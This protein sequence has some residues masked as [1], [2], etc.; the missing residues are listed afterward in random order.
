[1][2]KTA[3]VYI[4]LDLVCKE[5]ETQY[6]MMKI[7]DMVEKWKEIRRK[8]RDREKMPINSWAGDL[9]AK[10]ANEFMVPNYAEMCEKQFLAE[11]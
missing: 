1:M 6:I 4:A 10:V 2:D 8:F 3:A 5:R 7:P 11:Y 9:F